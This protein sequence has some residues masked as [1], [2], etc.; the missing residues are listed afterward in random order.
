MVKFINLNEIALALMSYSNTSEIFYHIDMIHQQ[1]DVYQLEVYENHRD[2]IH[3]A[4]IV[5]D[6]D[7]DIVSSHICAY[8][9]NDNDFDSIDVFHLTDN[10]TYNGIYLESIVTGE[11]VT[12]RK[13]TVKK[14]VPPKKVTASVNV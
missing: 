7:N 9:G 4:T 12:V 3:I 8:S 5:I 6:R 1:Q 14:A 11:L 2:G 10:G 13:P